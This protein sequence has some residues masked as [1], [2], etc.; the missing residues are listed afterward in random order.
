MALGAPPSLVAAAQRD[1]LDEIRHTEL[2]FGLARALDGRAASPGPFAEARKARTLSGSGTLAFAQL[3]L[4]SLVDGALHEGVSA[5]I[6]ARLAKRC[7][8]PAVRAILEE[9]AADE[10]RHAA[11]GWDV[12]TWCIA[13]GGAPVISALRGALGALSPVMNSPLPEGA[14]GGGWQRYGIHD[15]ALESEEYAKARADLGARIEG[16]RTLAT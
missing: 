5:R 10:G 3:A 11:D 9:I 7:E 13:E 16:P 1:A 12:V 15:H 2:C 8:L 6:I 4:D 14:K